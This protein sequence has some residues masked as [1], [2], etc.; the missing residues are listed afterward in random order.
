[1]LLKKKLFGFLLCVSPALSLPAYSQSVGDLRTSCEALKANGQIEPFD[2]KIECKGSFQKWDW[3]KG[4]KSFPN[5]SS[6]E[7]H[8]SMKDDRHHGDFSFEP[9]DTCGETV[10]CNVGTKTQYTV[11]SGIPFRVKEC[12]EI[13]VE[14][15]KARCEGAVEEYCADN[16][17]DS[18][19]SSSSSDQDAYQQGKGMGQCRKEVVQNVNTCDMYN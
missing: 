16:V 4:S 8:I 15:M 18:S 12:S 9:C 1:M 7:A 17:D 13:T 5:C 6:L 3:K 10:D 19:S 11:D 2:I 14:N